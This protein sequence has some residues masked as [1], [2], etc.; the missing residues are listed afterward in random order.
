MLAGIER[1]GEALV[2][3]KNILNKL[4]PSCVSTVFCEVL[5]ESALRGLE[6][7]CGRA[8]QCENSVAPLI[9][10]TGLERGGAARLLREYPQQV[11]PYCVSTVLGNPL[12]WGQKACPRQGAV[13][14]GERQCE[15]SVAPLIVLAGKGRGAQALG[16]DFFFDKFW[17]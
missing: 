6:G 13:A 8:R 4:F 2:F 15:N 11:V 7:R 3:C 1:G 12:G 17:L 9:V 5:F 14:P 16:L 10:L